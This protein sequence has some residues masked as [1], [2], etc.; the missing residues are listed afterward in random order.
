MRY[1]AFFLALLSPAAASAG[2]LVAGA[3]AGAVIV[4]APCYPENRFELCEV[5]IVDGH[6]P[7]YLPRTVPSAVTYAKEGE[8][9]ALLVTPNIVPY[10]LAVGQAAAAAAA[11]C[12]QQTGE[13]VVARIDERHRYAPGNLESWKFVGTCE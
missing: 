11:L 3:G 6:Y 2:G 12:G 4:E 10:E 1:L 8:H 9:F 5:P 13:V 7:G